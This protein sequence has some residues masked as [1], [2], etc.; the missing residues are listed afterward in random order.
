MIPRPHDKTDAGEEAQELS[1][2]TGE[3]AASTGTKDGAGSDSGPA[4]AI[5]GLMDS[6]KKRHAQLVATSTPYAILAEIIQAFQKYEPSLLAR[7]S[8]YSLL[9]AVPSLL[10]MILSLAAIVDQNTGS[11]VSQPLRD[12][13]SEEAPADL[14]PL[15]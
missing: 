13:I 7:Q 2:T 10:I 9:Y 14:Q 8:A 3:S 4:S 1:T 15:L 6:L 12:F 11:S 5:S